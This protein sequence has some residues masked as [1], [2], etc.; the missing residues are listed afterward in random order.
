MLLPPV[1]LRLGSNLGD[2]AA[3]IERA[4]ER[5]DVRGFH[6]VARSSLYLTEPVGGPPQQWYLNAVFGG[7]TTLA[8]EE[9]LAAGLEIERELGRVRRERDGPRPID[10]DLLFYGSER[11]ADSGLTL[12]HPRLHERRFVLVPLAEVAPGLRHPVLDLTAEEL[13]RRC[14][15]THAVRRL[16]PQAR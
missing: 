3:A 14:P 16:E 5:L 10:I 1:F 6:V 12:P 7:V 15:D 9:L 8:P 13:L 2:R 4:A 11:R